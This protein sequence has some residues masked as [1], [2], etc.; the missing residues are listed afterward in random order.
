MAGRRHSQ[1]LQAL[2]ALSEDVVSKWICQMLGRALDGPG[3]C[4]PCLDGKAQGGQPVQDHGEMGFDERL[5]T[6]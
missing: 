3:A 6:A 2:V 5:E 1:Y 4:H